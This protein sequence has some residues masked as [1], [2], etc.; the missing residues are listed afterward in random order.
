M[1]VI[2]LTRYALVDEEG[3]ELEDGFSFGP[4]FAGSNSILCGVEAEPGIFR[5]PLDFLANTNFDSCPVF[6]D[7]LLYVSQSTPEMRLGGHDPQLSESELL[8]PLD[9][10]SRDAKSR[11]RITRFFF[12]VLDRDTFLDANVDLSI[13]RSV[14]LPRFLRGDLCDASV[15]QNCFW[16]SESERDN[17]CSFQSLPP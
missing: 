16:R 1:T 3:H 5:I 2:A 10:S 8:C 15:R 6:T 17:A 12:G 7:G 13:H 9:G 11:R 4:C 14:E